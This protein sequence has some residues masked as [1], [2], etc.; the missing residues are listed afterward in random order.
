MAPGQHGRHNP[1]ANNTYADFLKTQPPIFTKADEPLETNDWI[2]TIEQKFGL[3]HCNG[4]QKTLFAAQQLQGPAGAWWE[5]YLA[6][7]PEGHQVPWVEFC[8]AFRA[9]HIPDDI[10]EMKLEEFLKLQQGGK[11]VMEYVGEV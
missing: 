3:I 5:S 2:R 1:K 8:D 10:M 9:H 6:I 4:N 7:Q 11:S